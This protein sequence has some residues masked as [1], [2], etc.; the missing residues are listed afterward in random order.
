VLN[1]AGGWWPKAQGAGIHR[2]SHAGPYP[3]LAS[4]GIVRLKELVGP[5]NEW[6]CAI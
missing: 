2:V 4:R 1:R 5:P 3:I 6:N